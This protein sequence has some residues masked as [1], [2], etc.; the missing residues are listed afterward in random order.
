[1]TS[2]QSPNPKPVV[3]TIATRMLYSTLAIGV[4][5]CSLE[6]SR[7]TQV[8]SP[9]L[10]FISMTFTLGIMLWLTY[11]M[12]NGRNWARITFLVLCI[13]GV[14]FAVLPLLRSLSNSPI[15]G[16]LGLAQ[17]ALQLAALIFL[18]RR[19]A[20]LWFRPVA[21]PLTTIHDNNRNA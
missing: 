17:V 21:I 19:D 6:W 14:P 15:S 1:M 13:L 8:T 3:V 12:D 7:L 9:V 2:P 20:R 5:R 11:K 4:I 16:A 18:F 10:I